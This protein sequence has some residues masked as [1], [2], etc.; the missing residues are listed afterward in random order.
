MEKTILVDGKEVKLK[1]NAGLLRRYRQMY[2]RDVVTDVDEI[3]NALAESLKTNESGDVLFSTLPINVLTI[4]E[5][6]AFAMNKYGDPDGTPDNI[7]DWLDGFETFNVYEIF[8]HI[9][10]LWNMDNETT[11]KVKKNKGKPL[12]K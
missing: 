8:P 4:F 9:I 6:L 12:E 3:M 1:T 10:E 7:D 11:S 2:G 5:D